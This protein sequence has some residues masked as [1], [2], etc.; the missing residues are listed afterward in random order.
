MSATLQSR[1]FREGGR[2]VRKIKKYVTVINNSAKIVT[3]ASY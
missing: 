3:A 1:N 2:E